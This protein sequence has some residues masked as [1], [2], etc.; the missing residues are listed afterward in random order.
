MRV[1][2]YSEEMTS[3]VTLVTKQVT[4]EKF[5]TRVFYGLRAFLKSPPEL[6]SDPEDDDRSAVTFWFGDDL[7]VVE[8]M[9]NGFVEEFNKV[10]AL[11]TPEVEAEHAFE[12]PEAAR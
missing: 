12:V 2:I 4:D 6:H 8:A 9:L 1:Q 5:G 3:E 7:D 10:K 11:R